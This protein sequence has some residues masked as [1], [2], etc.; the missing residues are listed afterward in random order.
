MRIKFRQMWGNSLMLSH[1]E[2]KA[3]RTT[4]LGEIVNYNSRPERCGQR[5]SSAAFLNASNQVNFVVFN[6]ASP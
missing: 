6:T 5:P 1:F 2:K 4:D 3:R